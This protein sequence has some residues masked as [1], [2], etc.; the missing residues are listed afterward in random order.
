MGETDT[1]KPDIEGSLNVLLGLVGL[2]PGEEPK[3]VKA[4]REA[5]VALR[6]H[7]A[8]V[9]EV[10]YN[11]TSKA[12][13]KELLEFSSPRHL[14]TGL[15]GL[16]SDANYT[17]A[18][19][20][21]EMVNSPFSKKERSKKYG[22]DVSIAEAMFREAK[23]DPSREMLKYGLGIFKHQED[24]LKNLV[25]YC[26]EKDKEPEAV[27]KSTRG[28]LD[29]VDRTY[30]SVEEYAET[31]ANT[32]RGLTKLIKVLDGFQKLPIGMLLAGRIMGKIDAKDMK[33][34]GLDPGLIGKIAQSYLRDVTAFGSG[35]LTEYSKYGL[36]EVEKLRALRDR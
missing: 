10:V 3:E 18:M 33:E 13:G 11:R 19:P 15:C 20:I 26:G 7:N 24:Y 23:D 16:V 12:V 9:L 4:V 2:G 5:S 17:L 14:I 8:K 22:E 30:G 1:T 28:R 32:S 34:V 25:E 27:L 35:F 29:L 31:Q 36:E 6:K 21:R